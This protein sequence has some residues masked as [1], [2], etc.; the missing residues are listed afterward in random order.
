MQQTENNVHRCPGK[1]T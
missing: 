1:Y